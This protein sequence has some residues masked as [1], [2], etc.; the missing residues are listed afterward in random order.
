[1]PTIKYFMGVN[2]PEGDYTFGRNLFMNDDGY[3]ILPKGDYSKEPY[4][5][6]E[7]NIQKNLSEE[8]MKQLIYSDLIIRSD[9]MGV[10]FSQKT[11]K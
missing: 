9:Y 10:L 7:L 11:E 3:A 2:G 8:Q 5:I 4:Y 6:D 1:M